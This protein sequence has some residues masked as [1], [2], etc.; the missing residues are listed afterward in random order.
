MS[1]FRSAVAAVTL[2]VITSLLALASLSAQTPKPAPNRQVRTATLSPLE[3]QM[4][5]DYEKATAPGAEPAAL[6]LWAK[7]YDIALRPGGRF[8]LA[9]PAVDGCNDDPPTGDSGQPAAPNACE[10]HC[11]SSLMTWIYRHNGY[12]K[13]LTCELTTCFYNPE[14][15]KWEC[16]Y[17][18]NCYVSVGGKVD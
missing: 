4:W 6:T 9:R 17:V 10:K 2:A 7:R 16:L 11:W 5:S 18:S 14:A 15:K 13:G 8:D 12:W 1:P 3:N